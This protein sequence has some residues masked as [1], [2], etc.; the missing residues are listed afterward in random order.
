MKMKSLSVPLFAL[1]ALWAGPVLPLSAQENG[2]QGQPGD[3]TPL[4]PD[5]KALLARI[6][7]LPGLALAEDGLRWSA[8]GAPG[9]LVVDEREG[10][11]V[12]QTAAGRIEVEK[13]V[14][15]HAHP[16]ALEVLTALAAKAMEGGLGAKEPGGETGLMLALSVTIG[17]HLR[18]EERIVTAQGILVRQEPAARSADSEL[19]ILAEAVDRF[20]KEVASSSHSSHARKAI[21]DFARLLPGK[22]GAEAIDEIAPSFARRLV[23]HGWLTRAGL[24]K[25]PSAESLARAVRQA[26]ELRPVLVYQD[27]ERSL[28]R[29]EDGFGHG[30]WVFKS[31]ERI[32]YTVPAALPL[33]QGYAKRAFGDAVVVVELGPGCDPAAGTIEWESVRTLRLVL[34]HRELASWSRQGGFACDE[35]AWREV[36]PDKGEGLEDAVA[37]FLPPHIVAT[38]P[39][40]DVLRILTRHGQIV[41][42][43]NGSRVEAERF[44]EEA[45]SRLPDAAHLDLIGEYLF[46]YVYDSPD[47][48]EPLL[49]GNREI[50][51]DIH[52]TAEQSLGT[53][54]GGICRGDCDDLSELYVTLAQRQGKTAYVL[55]LPMHAA[56]AWAEMRDAQWK[57]YVLQTGPALE[58]SHERLEK[59]LEAAYRAF[60]PS[61][62]F[63]PANLGLLLRFSGENTRSQW[64]LGYR[65]FSEPEY[66]RTMIDVQRDWHFQ[67]YLQGIRKMLALVESG[68][69]D[70]ANYRELAFLYN[71]TDQDDLAVEYETKAI[72]QTDDPER[73][74]NLNMELLPLL[75]EAK[76]DE[77]ARALAVEILDRDLPALR[78]RMDDQVLFRTGMDLADQL[79]AHKAYDLALQALD[80]TGLAVI[81]RVLDRIVSYLEG[82]G[83]DEDAWRNEYQ[84]RD[85]VRSQISSSISLL[86]ERG[87]AG[88]AEDERLQGLARNV[89]RYL[90]KIAMYDA[91]DKGDISQ[92]YALAASYYETVLGQE[93]LWKSLEAAPMPAG[94]ATYDHRRRVG[95]LLQVGLDLPWIKASVPYWYTCITQLVGEDRQDVDR[96]L[97]RRLHSRLHAAA[98]ASQE[99]GTF[100]PQTEHMVHMSDV[101]A[102]MVLSDEP[103][104]RRLLARVKALND[105]RRR[106]DTAEWMGNVARFVPL[107]WFSRAIE[108]WKE[109]VDYK[110]KYL[111]IAWRAA[112]GKAPKHALAAARAAAERFP[113]D[114]TFAEEYDFM[115]KLFE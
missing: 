97:L 53:V 55:N 54:A 76:K 89:Q 58:F 9:F 82:Q 108:I 95:G 105:R 74:L 103:A 44:L 36:V 31:P 21:A 41:P 39:E 69:H 107:D 56:A 42:P 111:W 88:M 96:E 8:E 11:L 16:Y 43:R 33:Y 67:T 52:Q 46:A 91:D 80:E 30:G 5:P 17:L 84:L 71:F 75:F 3:D 50:R 66:A 70:I 22:D 61:T 34:E 73:K 72:T 115:K 26:S 32:V 68:D 19:S 7:E 15:T 98:Q 113:D 99:L 64:N 38:D 6:G 79:V 14:L 81:A 63:D 12:V 83:F 90:D 60:D 35:A 51:S 48:T 102:A 20:E 45:S 112:V 78:E 59:A 85:L 57:V 109:E 101:I 40:G 24:D 10:R 27:E 37:D 87:T 1:L 62:P 104:L 100:D 47:A 114:S 29:F 23:R 2:G 93:E 92:R 94:G 18:S 110:P 28:A 4:A 13:E 65:I 86:H 25:T 77:E 106:D 49:L